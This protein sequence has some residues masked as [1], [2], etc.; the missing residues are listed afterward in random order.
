[1]YH[2]SDKLKA[3]PL[4]FSILMISACNGGS[5]GTANFVINPDSNNQVSTA[6]LSI[7]A[8]GV[9]PISSSHKTNYS[10]LLSNNSS[11][12]LR[13]QGSELLFSS[14]SESVVLNELISTTACQELAAKSNCILTVSL[15]V[16]NASNGYLD[17]RLDYQ[18]TRNKEFQKVAKL[19]KFTNQYE[20]STG[21][22][23][24][25]EQGSIVAASKDD[26]ATL[27]VPFILEQD[28]STIRLELNGQAPKGYNEIRCDHS[29]YQAQASCTALVAVD[30][31]DTT[32]EINLITT[33]IKNEQ[34]SH[35]MAYNLY[36]ARAAHLSYLL[37][38]G[39]MLEYPLESSNAD[40]TV[41]NDGLVAAT[42]MQFEA[43]GSDFNLLESD[44]DYGTGA[45]SCFR[46]KKSGLRPAEHCKLFYGKGGKKLDLTKP[47]L[48]K[49]KISYN[50]GYISVQDSFMIYRTLKNYVST[51]QKEIPS[52]YLRA[53]GYTGGVK[54][55]VNLHGDLST[56][57]A[58]KLDSNPFQFNAATITPA[59]CQLSTAKRS[60]EFT[61]NRF[62]LNSE[63]ADM[64]G[65][66]N[67]S[68]VVSVSSDQVPVVGKNI[69]YTA[70]SILPT[71]MLPAEKPGVDEWGA[72]WS[73]KANDATTLKKERFAKVA[74]GN[75]IIDNLTGLMWPKSQS[76]THVGT[77]GAIS[78]PLLKNFSS[79]FYWNG[80]DNSARPCGYSD[81]RIPTVNELS[82]LINF[83]EPVNSSW[84]EKNGFEEIDKSGMTT[85]FWTSTD[86]PH[87]SGNT[88]VV[89]LKTGEI[90]YK[91]RSSNYRALYVRGG[92]PQ[93]GNQF[94]E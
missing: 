17:F 14:L 73:D 52:L 66:K 84:L 5:Q 41:V 62:I 86:H 87:S 33:N 18:N 94:Q 2:L 26:K 74:G 42:D 83:G 89:D 9:F 90:T 3:L 1:M 22:A 71:I 24:A 56:T 91:I 69:F 88:M 19:I 49:Q 15:P 53:D 25:P 11:E 45:W 70:Q 81:W 16:T 38:G 50:N 63:Y 44:V 93:T 10:L 65:F 31:A 75:C 30:S 61:V 51:E 48:A 34:Q 57:V 58:P 59:F 47:S 35:R 37:K 4:L 7:S 46:Y 21:L 80:V 78:S 27:A 40:V 6:E 43:E 55:R 85:V 20:V 64:S 13:L 29:A 23:F 60:C 28:F 77:V 32:P 12:S 92:H 39:G 8:S 79:S 67:L 68:G 54:F 76:V 36:F 72:S 82:T